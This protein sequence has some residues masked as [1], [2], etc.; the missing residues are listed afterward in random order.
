MTEST[1]SYPATSPNRYESATA[2][3]DVDA[4]FTKALITEDDVLI[5]ARDSSVKTTLPNAEVAANQAAFLGLVTQIAGAKRVLEFGTLAG[6]S[7]IWFARAVGAA[8]QVVTLELEERNAQIARENFTAAHVAD[9][10]ELIVGP[11]IESAQRLIAS[12][13]APFDLVF[14]DADKPSNPDY[15]AAALQLTRSGAV[16]IIDNVVRNGAVVDASGTDP[17][18]EGVRKV[19]EAIANHPELDATAIQTV[20]I[21]GWDGLLIA[22]RR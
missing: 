7:T 12:N 20:G 15:L 6:Y 10:V 1:E 3:R 21:K 14:I 16:I 8:G 13:V 18:V 4:Y 19:T 17:R 2:W 5:Q 9:R 22:R 11:G